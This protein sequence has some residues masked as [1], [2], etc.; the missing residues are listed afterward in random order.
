MTDVDQAAPGRPIAGAPPV[1][2]EAPRVTHGARIAHRVDPVELGILAVFAVLSIWVLGLT[3][4]EIAAHGRIWTG[5]DGVFP[6]DQLGYLA[7]IRDSARHVL[8][9]DLFRVHP[10]PADFLQP[11][12]VISGGLVALGLS[13][14][15]ALLV[16][17]PVALAA[18]LAA[19]AA[20]VDRTLDG[21]VARRLALGLGLFFVGPGG[22]VAAHIVHADPRSSLRWSALSFD[23]SLGF[24]SWGYTFG[25]IALACALLAV[26][27]Y[28]R[29]RMTGQGLWAPGVLGALAS[30]FHPWQGATTILVVLAG[31]I[32]AGRG[33]GRRPVGL[34]LG[35]VLLTALPLL[36]FAI[37]DRGDASWD[38]ARAPAQ[39]TYPLWMLAVTV[40]PLAIPAALAYRVRPRGFP[41]LAARAWPLA[42]LAVFLGS[43]TKLGGIPTH[44][45][46]GIGIPLAVLAVEGVRSLPGPRRPPVLVA[47]LIALVILPPTWWELSTA[48][49]V[50]RAKPAY[51]RAVGAR[52]LAPGE[53]DALDYLRGRP[54]PGGVLTGSYLGPTVPAITG[55][56]TWVGNFYYTPDFAD[57][58]ALADRL[59]SGQLTPAAARALV[60]SSGARYVLADCQGRGSELAAQLGP[61]VSGDRRFGC[62]RILVLR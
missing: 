49:D 56:H 13:P 14:A 59:F 10:E 17:K 44:A 58:A 43:E 38:L 62:A 28:G 27:A 40:A 12:V 5:T 57:R 20:F 55:R 42:A 47:T 31:E 35:T 18:V 39:T 30:W 50:V 61:L 7:W 9:S 6:T 46:L 41:A 21:V 60:R 2:G 45:L 1:A 26:L 32:L 36:Y 48:R 29:A 23:A 19:A 3:L 24:W 16:W 54:G 37:L 53:R 25:L 52:F 11:L 8:A 4:W 34:S 51:A 33:R 22:F 15:A